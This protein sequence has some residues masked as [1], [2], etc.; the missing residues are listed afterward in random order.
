MV[1]DAMAKWWLCPGYTSMY[2]GERV[3]ERFIHSEDTVDSRQ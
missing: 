3:V 2:S 1:G